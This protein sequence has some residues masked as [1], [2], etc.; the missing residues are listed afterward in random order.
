[1]AARTAL[2]LPTRLEYRLHGV[3]GT[4]R[5][6]PVNFRGPMRFSEAP[7]GQVLRVSLRTGH[8]ITWNDMATV[9]RKNTADATSIP[10]LT[11]SEGCGDTASSGLM[12]ARGRLSRLEDSA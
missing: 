8:D 3:S 11:V 9:T 7:R 2:Q 5:A 1:M 4:Y 6:G 10:G 12:P